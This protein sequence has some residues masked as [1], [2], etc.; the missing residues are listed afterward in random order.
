MKLLVVSDSD[1]DTASLTT[2]TNTSASSNFQISPLLGLDAE[3]NRDEDSKG[4]YITVL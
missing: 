2:T 1:E 3:A 4:W